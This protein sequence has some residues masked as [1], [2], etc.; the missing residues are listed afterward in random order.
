MNITVAAA[1]DKSNELPPHNLNKLL[2]YWNDIL[3]LN[4][5]KIYILKY[6]ENRMNYIAPNVKEL[7]GWSVTAK[8]ISAAGGINE[9]ANIGGGN[10]QVLGSQ[11]KSLQGFS[12]ANLGLHIGVIGEVSMIEKAPASF[13]KQIVRMFSTKTALAARTD[14]VQKSRSG[15]Y[16]KIH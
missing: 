4:D 1:M 9:L 10:I 14:A 5:Q 7:L 8:L 11:K 12:T 16:G 6:L 15:E 3:S 2:Y 13:K